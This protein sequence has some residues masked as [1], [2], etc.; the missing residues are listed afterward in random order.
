LIGGEGSSMW[1]G[2]RGFRRSDVGVGGVRIVRSVRDGTSVS[3]GRRLEAIRGI[4]GSV[5]DRWRFDT[6]SIFSLT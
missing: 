1:R 3:S 4:V 2:V 5:A 6:D